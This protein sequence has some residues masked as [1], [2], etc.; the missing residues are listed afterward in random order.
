MA[1][2]C[3]QS[4]HQSGQLGLPAD[5]QQY[6][7]CSHI[8]FQ[9]YLKLKKEKSIKAENGVLATSVVELNYSINF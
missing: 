7:H 9:S 2:L 8:F 3:G 1:V 4:L 5:D 6:L